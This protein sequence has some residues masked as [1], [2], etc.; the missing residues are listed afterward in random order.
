MQMSVD[1]WRQFLLKFGIQAPADDLEFLARASATSAQ[2]LQPR[3]TTEP[4]LVQVPQPWVN[5]Q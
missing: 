1:E 3:L 5:R 4:Q 2:E